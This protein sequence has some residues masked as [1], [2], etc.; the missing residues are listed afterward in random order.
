MKLAVLAASL[1]LIA[2]SF[3]ETVDFWPEG[4]MP[5]KPIEGKE[6][7]APGR[8][9]EDFIYRNVG[10]PTLTIS[11]A[12]GEGVHPAMLICPG[13]G[14]FMLAWKLEGLEIA[15]WANSIGMDAY[16]LKYRVPSDG[17]L[18]LMDAQ[19]AL[20]WM[21][22]NAAEL[23]IDPKKIAQIGFSAGAN[24]TARTA[25]CFKSRKYEAI[26]EV[27][28]ASSRPDAT[29]LIYP[30]GLFKGGFFARPNERLELDPLNAVT[31]ETPPAFLTQ[32]EDDFCGVENCLAYYLACKR[33]GVD[34]AMIL[35][36][37]GGHGY[38]KR[39]T[40]RDNDT[41]PEVAAAWLKRTLGF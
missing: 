12:P 19:R 1:G 37:K 8:P 34:A 26:D 20:S 13:G 35:G 18:A 5:G 6:I 30:A 2:A 40:G 10:H 17:G 41:W 27:D 4:K 29:L 28:E 24:L 31:R 36:P 32:T 9:K 21:R 14:Y 33:A 38:G 25:G 15:E 39:P 16:I 23:K 7:I 3:G 22:H 11:R